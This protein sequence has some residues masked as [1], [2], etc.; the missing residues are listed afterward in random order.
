[1]TELYMSISNILFVCNF[2]SQQPEAF[3]QSE[4]ARLQTFHRESEIRGKRFRQ[5]RILLLLL[6]AILVTIIIVYVILALAQVSTDSDVPVSYT[7]LTFAFFAGIA[8]WQTVILTM[9]YFVIIKHF[10]GSLDR[11]YGLLVR[12]QS[13]LAFGYLL[14][15]ILVILCDADIWIEFTRDY[16]NC[17]SNNVECQSMDIKTNF[18]WAALPL[19]FIIYAIIPYLTIIIAHWQNAKFSEQASNQDSQITPQISDRDESLK[20]TQ[21]G[22]NF[23]KFDP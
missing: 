20:Q 21:D 15:F 17:M 6:T 5:L 13:V 9:L 2:K 22:Q 19:Q 7:I 4:I 14:R 10:K 18:L 11:E 8:S 16:P 23:T 1:M 3:R 12:C